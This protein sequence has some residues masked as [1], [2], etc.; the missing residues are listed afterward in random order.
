MSHLPR[1]YRG[2]TITSKVVEPEPNR[3]RVSRLP[4]RAVARRGQIQIEGIQPIVGEWDDLVRA[5]I[6]RLFNPALLR[7]VANLN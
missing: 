5:E 3:E 4:A 6:D 1:M 7:G 2:F